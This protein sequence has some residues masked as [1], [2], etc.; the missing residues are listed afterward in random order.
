M[1]DRYGTTMPMG[2][3]FLVVM[4]V[5]S[6]SAYADDRKLTIPSDT[7]LKQKVVLVS[8]V[9]KPDYEAAKKPAD[10][11]ELA[12]KMILDGDAT[13]D[14]PVGKFVLYRIARDIAAQQGDLATALDAIERIDEKYEIEKGKMQ[15]EAAT[16]AVKELKKSE[17]FRR[18]VL[19]LEP[20]IDVAINANQFDQAKAIAQLTSKCA[21]QSRDSETASRVETKLL[22]IQEI[23]IAFDKVK[24]S[25]PVSYTH[26]TLPTNREV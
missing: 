8:E 5:L 22:E 15:L 6:L 23:A 19:L 17:E 13:T 14:D 11:I 18:A 4:R 25:E 2:V 3:A 10:R 1:N 21:K 12:K 20:F 26:L 24:P 16:T 7:A 9:Y